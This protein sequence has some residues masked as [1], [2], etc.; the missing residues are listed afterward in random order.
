MVSVCGCKEGSLAEFLAECF[1]SQNTVWKI[2]DV[3]T[4]LLCYVLRNREGTA[5]NLESV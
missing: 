1:G 3:F 4:C 5:Q 2:G